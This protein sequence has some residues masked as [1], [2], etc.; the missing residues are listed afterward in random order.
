MSKSY[1]TNKERKLLGVNS[2]NYCFLSI[3]WRSPEMDVFEKDYKGKNHR[4]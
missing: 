4:K 2:G 1:I 3:S